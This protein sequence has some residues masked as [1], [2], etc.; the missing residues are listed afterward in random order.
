MS[1]YPEFELPLPIAP[2]GTVPRRLVNVDQ[3]AAAPTAGASFK[4]FLSGLPR[5]CAGD[6]IRTVASR[7]VTARR[8]NRAVVVACGAHVVKCG[9]S[10]VLIGL[11]EQG[12]ITALAVNCAVAIHDVE[13]ALSGVTSEDVEEGL[14]HGTFGMADEPS[15]F[16]NAALNHA[17]ASGLGAGEAIGMALLE[18]NPQFAEV[19]VLAAAYRLRIPVTVHIAIGTDIIHMHAS[20][21]GAALGEASLRDFRILT[22]AM[23]GLSDGGVL[24][25]IGSAVILPE[26]LLKAI[27]LLRRENAEFS[28]FLGVD[29]DFIRQHRATQ[30]LVQRVRAIGGEGIALTGHHEILLP[31]IAFA[32]MEAGGAQT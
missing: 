11:M 16:I 14:L 13:I 12:F 6:D 19:S 3:F 31:L 9:L 24:L 7:I 4:E 25:N 17:H 1:R 10:P 5:G 30:Q 15:T 2:S 28:R 18:A 26:V 8:Q 21:D 23:R 20:A 29:C 32:V 22:A 27:A